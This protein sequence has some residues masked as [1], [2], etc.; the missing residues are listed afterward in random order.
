[1]VFIVSWVRFTWV[2]LVPK[3]VCIFHAAKVVKILHV[4]KFDRHRFI[5]AVAYPLSNS[6]LSFAIG[7]S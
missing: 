4:K 1:M 3:F 2:I 5:G 7:N 6:V